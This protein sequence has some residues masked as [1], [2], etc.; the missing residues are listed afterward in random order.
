MIII[1]MKTKMC[2]T[3]K[4]KNENQNWLIHTHFGEV[5]EHRVV[6]CYWPWDCRCSRW[7]SS[8]PALEQRSNV[9][10]GTSWTLL[11][12]Q[13]SFSAAL[14]SC[15]SPCFAHVFQCSNVSPIDS[16]GLYCAISYCLR[17][18]N[19]PLTVSFGLELANY[20]YSLAL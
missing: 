9:Y 5:L 7:R 3:K 14:N 15:T 6:L 20:Y 17:F 18:G 19:S 1:S 13:C 12:L 2:R 4:E 11:S 10:I 8:W 16:G